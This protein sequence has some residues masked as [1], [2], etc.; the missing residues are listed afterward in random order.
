MGD[1]HWVWCVFF[2]HNIVYIT[3]L[4]CHTFGVKF[5]N[6]KT[7]GCK[8]NYRYQLSA[9]VICIFTIDTVQ[10]NTLTVDMIPLG[11]YQEPRI[12]K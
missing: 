8:R 5:Q 2:T 11:S 6:Q 10:G 3:Y 1:T 12:E 9:F 4:F 7:R